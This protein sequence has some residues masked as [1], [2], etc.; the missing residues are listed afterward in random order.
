V[1]G[2]HLHDVRQQLCRNGMTAAPCKS[3]QR[4]KPSLQMLTT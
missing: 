1:Q 4:T 2:R 3:Q